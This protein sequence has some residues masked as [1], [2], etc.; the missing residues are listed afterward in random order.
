MHLTEHQGQH[1][2]CEAVLKSNYNLCSGQIS[3]LIGAAS[4]MQFKWKKI[5]Y[6]HV[7]PTFPY[8]KWYITGKLIAWA[9]YC[10]VKDWWSSDLCTITRSL[11]PNLKGLWA[12]FFTKMM[13]LYPKIVV[14]WLLFKGW[15]KIIISYSKE[16]EWSCKG[17]NSVNFYVSPCQWK[18]T[19]K[20][21][22]LLSRSNSVHLE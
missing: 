16:K 3:V 13:A 11:Q 12:W 10:N 5:M 21:E 18:S 9:C 1:S 20:A 19:L 17:G 14:R 7:Y 8:I 22:N 2:L 15:L 6:I 4:R